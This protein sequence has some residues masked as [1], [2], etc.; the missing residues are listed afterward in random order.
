MPCGKIHALLGAGTGAV[1]NL[2]K[3]SEQMQQDAARPFNWGELGLYTFGGAV[4][5]GLADV[6]EPATT[7]NHRGFFHSV[8]L[9]GAVLYATHGR[10]TRNWDPE[11]RAALSA[12]GYCYI[13]HLV[14]D[15]LTPKGVRLI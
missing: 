2:I 3:Q 8:A 5:G 12:A 9:G 15:A 11:T 10:H 6:L 13:S 14:A 1:A 4:I 7:P